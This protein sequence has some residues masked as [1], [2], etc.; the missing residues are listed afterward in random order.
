[1]EKEK[2]DV[3]EQFDISTVL[4]KVFSKSHIVFFRWKVSQNWDVKYATE[5]CID[6]YGYSVNEFFTKKKLYDVIVHPD[7][8]NRVQNEIIANIN[9]KN[10][11]YRH[12]PYRIIT[13]DKQLKWV[14]DF[15]LIEYDDLGNA[16]FLNGF[17]TDIT[18]RINIDRRLEILTKGIENSPATVV[19]T[20]IEGRLIYINTKF[21]E[22]TGYSFE[23]VKDKKLNFIQSGK[24]DKN[25]YKEMWET[26]LSGK[27]WEG[28]ICNRKK[29]GEYFWEYLTITPI[30]D[31]NN[32]ITHFLGIK[33]DITERKLVETKLKES[34]SNFSSL[35]NNTLQSFI[36]ITVDKKIAAFNN[37]AYR[38][39]QLVFKRTM[40]INDS[41]YDFV[42]DR[43]FESFNEN[44]DR[45][46]NGE[47]FI[48]EKSFKVDGKEMTFA[49]NFNPV[50]NS[51]GSVKAVSFG[52]LDLTDLKIATN[53]LASTIEK[54]NLAL[55]TAKLSWW[56]WDINTGEIHS[57]ANRNITLGYSGK[58]APN[59]YNSVFEIMHPDD[60]EKTNTALQ[61]YLNGLSNSYNVEFRIKNSQDKYVW[62]HDTGKISQRDENGIPTKV[63]GII[64]NIDERKNAEK[65]KEQILEEYERVVSSI[66]INIWKTTFDKDANILSNYFSPIINDLVEAESRS[67]IGNSFTNYID[68]IHP[69]DKGKLFNEIKESVK[70]RYHNIDV[71]Y[72]IITNSNKI[73]FIRSRGLCKQIN[74]NLYEAYGYKEDITSEILN[75]E[76]I[77]KNEKRL[78]SLID[79]I[80][81]ILFVLDKEGNY[82]DIHTP[83]DELLV[84]PKSTLIGKNINQFLE[85]ELVSRYMDAIN[86]TIRN[87][88][89]TQFD[90]YLKVPA[91]TKYFNARIIKNSE[92][93]VLVVIRDITEKKIHEE[94]LKKAKEEAE[95]SNRLK[96]EFLAQMSHEI[97]TP[98]NAMLSF[99]SLLK[100]EIS[101][102]I[103]ED[104]KE[105]FDIISN[106][107]NRLIRTIDLILDMSDVQAGTYDYNP[108]NVDINEVLKKLIAEFSLTAKTKG[109][110]LKSNLCNNSSVITVDEYTIRQ[111][112]ANLIDNAIKYTN[113]G[114][115][116]VITYFNEDK[117]VAEVADTG[118]GIN[119][120]NK[121]L[122]FEPFRQEYQ[123][124]SRRF[125]GNG[126]G[127]ALVKNYCEM[128]KAHIEV[129][130]KKGFGSKFRVIF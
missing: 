91:G 111:I 58:N 60:R 125:E 127:L 130:S 93:T 33:E 7:D 34:E 54:L 75:R 25:F 126:L 121:S 9:L 43:D 15:T 109:L 72:R 78:K 94:E 115:V 129:E 79:T 45:C 98:I 4:P 26:I 22:L 36:L 107:G 37:K 10:E 53:S 76:I 118:I 8:I 87:D 80:P 16:I 6:L 5:N 23:E 104:L 32:I 82:V 18:D 57:D 56:E 21:E 119:E 90:Y 123:G 17:I 120:E 24:H 89:L 41:I 83:K 19:V 85:S 30:K 86:S 38:N 29:N 99:T 96:S 42:E 117:L 128:N 124:Y 84:N 51:D 46:L 48:V 12:K 73:K 31:F 122:I 1:M 13:K 112:F 71:E 2:G 66:P 108:Q 52:V 101:S 100:D 14:D 70:N 102:E 39:A 40:R 35:I 69:D 95:K 92:D 81:D 47:N 97:R 77:E 20:D 68:Y 59:S 61:N 105:S 114:Y 27:S 44:F 106:A 3:K 49:F 11:S 88:K 64:Q 110:T 74:E 67:K 116:E 28:E 62:Y 55:E 113:E 103:D 65:A 63:I 50:I